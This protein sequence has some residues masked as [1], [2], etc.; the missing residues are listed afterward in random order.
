MVKSHYVDLRRLPS[1]RNLVLSLFPLLLSITITSCT[2]DG[3][4]DRTEEAP[5][6][7]TAAD[8]ASA[9]EMDRAEARSERI[10]LQYKP[11]ETYRYRI[12][13]MTSMTQDTVTSS[14]TNTYLYSKRVKDRNAAGTYSVT[15]TIDSVGASMTVRTK[16]AA[17]PVMSNSFSSGD[18]AQRKDPQYASLASLIG[19]PVTLTIDT[20]G[21]ISKITGADS[22]AR[23]MA[24]SV[25]AMRGVGENEMKMLAAQIEQS[26]Y[27]S[28]AGQ[29][30]VPY[31]DEPLDSSLSWSRTQSLPGGPLFQ[32]S[33]KATYRIESIKNVKGRRL[34]TV[35]AE[36]SG[37]I[38]PS[39][40][41]EGSP[42]SVKTTNSAI[43]GSSRAVIDLDNGVTI[44]KKNIIRMQVS[45]T[46]TETSS[47][48]KEAFKQAQ[49]T[50][51]SV[52]LLP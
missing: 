42:V 3:S 5:G 46:I 48:R 12:V 21:K 32:I 11:N 6:T 7:V 33:A 10:T 28:F 26:V 2:Q 47:G 27:G 4:N 43:D 23:R 25:P 8:T 22:I 41:P 45:G 36:I 24:A 39:K 50:T 40:A 52:D 15:M 29:E 17:Q 20:L 38:S 31:P 1:L 44:S 30:F 19:I 14:N 16:G 37:T 9:T 49:E 34:A 18:T 51:Y 35:V 13:Q